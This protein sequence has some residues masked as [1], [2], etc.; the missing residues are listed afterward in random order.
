MEAVCQSQPERFGVGVKQAPYGTYTEG[1]LVDANYSP[2]T[3]KADIRPAKVRQIC[4]LD[5]TSRL[6][7]QSA[8]SQLQLS[9]RLYHR[10]L[11]LARAIADQGSSNQIQPAH[12][13]EAL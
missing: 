5:K 2:I 11:K 7:T 13:P 10:I 12:Q 1:T 3:C 8:M 6:L 9:A 4:K